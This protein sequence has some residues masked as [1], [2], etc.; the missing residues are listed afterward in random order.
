MTRDSRI[1]VGL[2]ALFVAAA[3]VAAAAQAWLQKTD[4]YY[5]KLS[6]SYLR[7]DEQFDFEGN[8]HPIAA[9][10][11]AFLD[12]S[13]RDVSLSAYI[14]YGLSE[15]FTLVG[16]LPFKISTTDNSRVPLAPNDPPVPFSLTNGGLSDFWLSLRTGLLQ[17][18]T[19]L[20]VQA[21]VKTPLGYEDIPDNGG[22]ALGTGEFDAQVDLLFGQSLYPFPAYLGAGVGY[23][24][25]GGGDLFDEIV[26][27]IEGGY[28]YGPMFFKLRFDALQNVKDPPDAAG[29]AVV[30]PI[31]GG[32]GALSADQPNARNED[33]FKLSPTIAYNISDGLGIAAEAYHAFAGKNTIA[34]TT[35]TVAV[36][37][38]Q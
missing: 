28:T 29:M 21:G 16:S 4:G 36:V 31:P 38:S 11:P 37:F 27:N 17:G 19:A 6:I 8:R 12:E 35:W 14:E 2:V 5:F 1:R 15:R 24:V 3:P 23:R 7:S 10:D 34:G 33:S 22:P 20:S 30:T 26:Y 32:G 25:R 13:F 9:D 18:P